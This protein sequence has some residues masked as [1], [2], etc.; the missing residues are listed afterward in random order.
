MTAADRKFVFLD[1]LRVIQRENPDLS[2]DAVFTKT[3]N[4][5]PAVVAEMKQPERNPLFAPALAPLKSKVA[6]AKF[7]GLVQVAKQA[8]SISFEAAWNAIRAEEPELYDA[9]CAGADPGGD[10]AKKDPWRTAI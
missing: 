5:L 9:M 1:K 7:S 3:C 6:S 2:Y 8:R 4:S 10:A